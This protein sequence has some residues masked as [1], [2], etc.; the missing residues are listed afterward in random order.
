MVNGDWV[1]VEVLVEVE[2]DVT[3]SVMVEVA[4]AVSVN[5]GSG[6]FVDVKVSTGVRD[7]VSA[8]VSGM[9]VRL[10]VGVRLGGVGTGRQAGANSPMKINP[11]KTFLFIS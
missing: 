6:V 7:G 2:V 9:G 5:V 11:I 1:A 4:V 8:W 3:V 10:T